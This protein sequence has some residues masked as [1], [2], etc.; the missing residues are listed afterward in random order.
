M[1]YQTAEEEAA[2]LNSQLN[3]PKTAEDEAAALNAE[4]QFT[5]GES[6]TSVT[7][8]PGIGVVDSIGNYLT[9]TGKDV[10]ETVTS[11]EKATRLGLEML[12]A[13][14]GGVIGSGAAPVAGSIAGGAL[15]FAAG[16]KAGD[17]LWGERLPPEKANKA[18]PQV[19]QSMK[20]TGEG[21][22]YEAVPPGLAK[23]GQVVE[24]GL[25]LAKNMYAK[26]PG[27]AIAG[28]VNTGIK[29]HA[30]RQA[31]KEILSKSSASPK[32]QEMI[33]KNIPESQS[34]E[35]QIP[36]LQFNIG[37]KTGDP[38]LLGLAQTQS[39]TPGA[40]TA[41]ANMSMAEQN[42]AMR[43]VIKER[44]R[45]RGDTGNFTLAVQKKQQGLADEVTRTKQA[46]EDIA[47]GK[48]GATAQEIGQEL[49]P[50]IA[51]ERATAAQ[52]AERLYGKVPEDLEIN[53]Q[54]LWDKVKSVF[55]GYD[56]LTQRLSATPTGMMSRVRKAMKPDEKDFIE[57]LNNTL[58]VGHTG[59]FVDAYGNPIK[60]PASL[61]PT[62][63]MKQIK[64]FRSQVSTF[65][66]E[67]IV[68]RDFTLAENLQQ[69][70]DGVN[71][72]LRVAA[73]T[74][75]GEG[76]KA[77]SDATKF[78]R[79]TYIPKFRE[80]STGKILSQAK[81]GERTI[82][83]SSIGGHYFKPDKA[84][85]AAEAADQ[86]NYIF[87]DDPE[88][89]GLISD[90]AAQDLL[91]E[92]RDPVTRELKTKK[93]ETWLY[94]HK[95]T[96]DKFGLTS[97][98]SDLQKAMKLADTAKG[99]EG[100]F[101][102]TS[103]ARSLNKNPDF[104]IEAALANP[105]ESIRNVQMMVDLAKSDPAAM[106]G[107]RAGIA[108]YFQRKINLTARDIKLRNEQ[109]MKRID[110]FIVYYKPAL[111]QSKLYTPEQLKAFD[112]VHQAM[113]KISQQQYVVAGKNS[114]TAG[115]LARMGDMIGV[116][117]H[118][119]PIRFYG[120]AKKFSKYFVKDEVEEALAKAVF[121]PRYAEAISGLIQNVEKL[122]ANQARKIFNQNVIAIEAMGQVEPA[123]VNKM[124]A[125]TGGLLTGDVDHSKYER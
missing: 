92:G 62:L 18:L 42:E 32:I 89:K 20:D 101:N 36:G 105:K 9:K 61:P 109:S 15:G 52:E 116:S 107:L 50:K 30:E 125:K 6:S 83:P 75:Q 46:A 53:A 59:H 78:W 60:A 98:F 81:T 121:D 84:K 23:A 123:R 7:S 57:E 79:E 22:L 74:G 35:T 95:N 80:G 21:L 111:E 87:K 76:I 33:E 11:P 115:L 70:K 124:K 66:R 38:N 2:A 86:F 5:S 25:R 93:I 13:G 55:T 3:Q 119:G 122:P 49:N 51:K 65:Q 110:D 63:T 58:G 106:D 27:T 54:P 90:F 103:L 117:T 44:V 96:L 34:L 73:E 114:Q 56:E 14:V 108:D 113:Q 120:I 47:A 17:L 43:N 40:G 12:G 16:R 8:P 97:E 24:G 118:A 1:A 41:Y 100:I 112:A 82:E 71:D 88:A 85:G 99:T 39:V 4:V 104:A 67:A 68:N 10:Y 77:L 29:K 91:R 19:W 64:D 28:A 48:E 72:T 94:Q 26:G 69:L 102:K 31:A 45:G 37:Q